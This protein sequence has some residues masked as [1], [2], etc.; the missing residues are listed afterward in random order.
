MV[1][2]DILDR[3]PATLLT[4]ADVEMLLRKVGIDGTDSVTV[5][6]IQNGSQNVGAEGTD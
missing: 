4:D 6:D 1:N 5:E 2:E 3:P